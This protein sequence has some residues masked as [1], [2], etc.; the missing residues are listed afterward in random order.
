ME[1]K[2]MSMEEKQ[3]RII[4]AMKIIDYWHNKYMCSDGYVNEDDVKKYFKHISPYLQFINEYI[5][6]IVHVNPAFLRAFE[7]S[8]NTYKGILMYKYLNQIERFD[9]LF[10]FMKPH[11]QFDRF[12]AIWQRYF[13][14]KNIVMVLA[15]FSRKTNNL[16]QTLPLELLKMIVSFNMYP[17]LPKPNQFA[18]AIIN[19]RLH[20]IYSRQGMII[21]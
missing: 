17:K 1:E 3:N 6:E 14:E 9:K 7:K 16:F 5:W 4:D 15:Y 21:I 13:M 2:M 20:I 18:E 10:T 19:N 12:N 11:F 8:I